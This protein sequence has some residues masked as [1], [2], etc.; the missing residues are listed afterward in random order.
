[1]KA[2]F[3]GHIAMISQSFP[4]Q[5]PNPQAIHSHLSEMLF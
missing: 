2:R 4:I 1:M 5:A 3:I